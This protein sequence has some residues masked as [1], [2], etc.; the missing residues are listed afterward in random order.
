[1]TRTY[2]VVYEAGDDNLSG[3]AP[4]VP[5]CISTA[6]D[7]PAMRKMMREAL[8]F[9]LKGLV[10]DGDPIPDAVTSNVDFS[11]DRPEHG[12]IHRVVKWLE[13]KVPQYEYQAAG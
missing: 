9:H 4:D 6:R 10:A 13:V 11:L 3:F 12:V 2:L 8:E 5:G 1:M 7:L